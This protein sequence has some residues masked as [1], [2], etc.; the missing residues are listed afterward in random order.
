MVVCGVFGLVLYG[1]NRCNNEEF[2]ALIGLDTLNA[3]GEDDSDCNITEYLACY[4]GSF[5]KRK[6]A[7]L[8]TGSK[9]KNEKQVE[10][11]KYWFKISQYD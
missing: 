5:P 6:V 3:T 2:E 9:V 1:K 11:E 10:Y 7:K 8:W 4:K